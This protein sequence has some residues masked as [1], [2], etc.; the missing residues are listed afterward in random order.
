MPYEENNYENNDQENEIRA[1][2]TGAAVHRCFGFPPW[3]GEHFSF[4]C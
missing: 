4:A 3:W 2:E 1:R